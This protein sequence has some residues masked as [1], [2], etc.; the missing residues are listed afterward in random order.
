MAKIDA[1]PVG[2]VEKINLSE[3]TVE[4]GALAVATRYRNQQVGFF[5]IKSFVELVKKEGYRRVVSL[6]KN[7]KLK[8]IYCSVGF[9]EKIPVD[10]QH[11]KSKSP[12]VP[13]FVYML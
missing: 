7:P 13:M 12:N 2:C 3:N 4:L 1:I 11:R 10:L 6:T 9:E 8:K 5:L